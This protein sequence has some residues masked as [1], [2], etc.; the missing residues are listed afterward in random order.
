MPGVPRQSSLM[1]P[2]PEAEPVI[3]DL[4]LL[5]DPAARLGV[6][7][8]VTVLY[9]FIPA[10]EIKDPDLEALA[11]L[12]GKQAE[13]DYRFDRLDGFGHTT[14]YLP[15]ESDGDF[16]H[17]TDVIVERWPQ[18]PPYEDTFDEVV[19]HLTVGD[20]LDAGS[21]APLA[22]RVRDVLTDRGPITG[23]ATSV[24]LIVQDERGQWST[25]RAFPLAGQR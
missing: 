10:D 19:P 5:H 8:H 22:A 2:I 1:V 13:F 7:A 25:L 14:V 18:H 11:S 6:P 16:K 23:R 20:W 3:G 15:P 24:H 12:L 17:L 21:A 4:R 9:P